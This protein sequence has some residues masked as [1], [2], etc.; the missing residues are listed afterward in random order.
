MAK[1][2]AKTGAGPTA[3]IAIEQY[4]PKKERII[5]DELAYKILPNGARAFLW[6]M[7]FKLVRNWMVRATEKDAPGIWSGMMCRKRYIDEKLIDSLNQIDAVVNLG[8]GFDTRAYRLPAISGKPVFELDQPQNIK[9][10]KERLL[11]VFGSIPSHVRLVEIDFD[12]E[13][14]G[15][16]LKSNGYSTDKRTFFIWEAVTQYLTEK[17]IRSTFDFLA[18]AATGS[19]IA[20]TYVIKDFL[21]GRAMYDWEKGYK[22]WVTKEIWIFG[23]EQR[24]W[25]NFLKDYG[26]EVIE[27]VGYDE[28]ADKYV[29]P[30]GR[31]LAS[32][33]IERMV[34]A[35]KL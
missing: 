24:M 7:N 32:T 21:D 5:E 1:A 31:I 22:K 18:Q 12:H 2:A 14:L 26:W 33:P 34:Y 16:V 27:D 13:D 17:G 29:K 9:S 28:L 23:M 19:R 20:F 4:F 3:V 35:E 30:S 25:S 6:F 11:N 8:A 15:T 10:K